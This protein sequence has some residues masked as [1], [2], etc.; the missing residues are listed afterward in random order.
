MLSVK[1]SPVT[2]VIAIESIEK[3]STCY[4]ALKSGNLSLEDRGNLL[5]ASTLD[6]MVISHTGTI[7]VHSMGYSLTYFKDVDHGRANVYY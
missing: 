2:D 1:A 3:I 4:A 6:G 5:Y 7:A